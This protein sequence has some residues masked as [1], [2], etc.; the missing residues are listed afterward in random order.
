MRKIPSVDV[1]TLLSPPSTS[2]PRSGMATAAGSWSGAGRRPID[3]KRSA[4]AAWRAVEVDLDLDAGEFPGSLPPHEH[5]RVESSSAAA[6]RA[7]LTVRYG[8]KAPMNRS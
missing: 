5:V 8:G 7:W 6:V 2:V 1:S 4:A 3:R